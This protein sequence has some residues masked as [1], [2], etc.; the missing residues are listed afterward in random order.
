MVDNLKVEILQRK[1]MAGMKENV[2]KNGQHH[3]SR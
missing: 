1:L 2:M 3:V